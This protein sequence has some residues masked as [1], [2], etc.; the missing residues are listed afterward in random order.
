[1]RTNR[2]SY[3]REKRE[4]SVAATISSVLLKKSYLGKPALDGIS[5]SSE[6]AEILGVIGHNGAGKTTLLKCLAGLTTPDSGSLE[7]NGVD[8]FRDPDSVKAGIGYLPEESRL[9]EQMNV[10]EYL[11][12]FG[13]VY[14]LGRDEI[15]NRSERLLLSLSL[16]ANGKKCGE[17]SKGMKRKVAIAR[18]LIHDPGLLIYD[19]PAS[20]LDPMTSRYVTTYL[21][22]LR[23][24]GKT[25]ILSAHN[26]YQVEAV[27]D[28][29]MILKDGKIAAMG[30][31]QELREEFGSLSYHIYFTAPEP[32]RLP[33]DLRRRRE[34][35]MFLA[36]APEIGVLNRILAE[37]A[38]CGGA[39]ERIE[40]HYPSLEEMLVRLGP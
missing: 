34:A 1:M 35:G 24:S 9:Y 27:C 23:D 36:E 3:R 31:L 33:P 14:A 19:E 4:A 20:G 17:L 38:S 40:S 7:V 13:E 6:K 8:M 2:Y 37:I 25:V 32:A 10:M 22:T 21:Q 5:F 12:F 16:S 11:R 39:V 29:V 15:R 28:R 18:S 30:T 26:L